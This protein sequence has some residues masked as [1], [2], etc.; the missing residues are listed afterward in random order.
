MKSKVVSLVV[1]CFVS[2]I[3]FGQSAPNGIAIKGGNVKNPT[4]NNGGNTAPAP[5]KASKYS[6][7]AGPDEICPSDLW[8]E[9]YEKFLS[10]QSKYRPAPPPPPKMSQE[11]QDQLTGMIV[12]LNSQIPKGYDWNGEK[13]RYVKK[14]EAA[15]VPVP[16]P[17]PAPAPVPDTSPKPVPTPAGSPLPAPT[18]QVPPKGDASVKTTASDVQQARK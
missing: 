10:I 5:A 4:V 9:D 11:M 3:A 17:A 12:R 1:A 14:V 7:V 6:C 18:Q 13:K 2:M 15:Q 16:A 8:M